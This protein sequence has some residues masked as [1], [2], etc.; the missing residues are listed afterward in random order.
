MTALQTRIASIGRNLTGINRT[1]NLIGPMC[2]G[3]KVQMAT[4]PLPA[5]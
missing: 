3:L 2:F 5:Y 4:G 1:L